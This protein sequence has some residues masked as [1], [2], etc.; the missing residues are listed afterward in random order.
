MQREGG[1][2]CLFPGKE[3]E[4]TGAMGGARDSVFPIQWFIQSALLPFPPSFSLSVLRAPFVLAF[5]LH[6]LLYWW[7]NNHTTEGWCRGQLAR[8]GK[9]CWWYLIKSLQQS[10][11]HQF[12]M[13]N[14]TFN[15]G[16]PRCYPCANHQCLHFFSFFSFFWELKISFHKVQELLLRPFPPQR[17]NKE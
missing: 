17:S 11:S 15:T 3:P 4:T 12:L 14:L 1:R 13:M 2:T 5:N 8:Q 10:L 6:Q 7:Y 16:C 9:Q